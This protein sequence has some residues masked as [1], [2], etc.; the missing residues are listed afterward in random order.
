[1]KIKE[2][3]IK[4]YLFVIIWAL[5]TTILSVFVFPKFSADCIN[6]DS[7]YQYF[8][9]QHS[10][11]EIWELLPQDYSPPVYALLLKFYTMIFGNTLF[12][13]RTM[14]VIIISAIF[15]ITL[16]PFRTAFGTKASIVYT[17]SVFCSATLL[18][19][20]HEIRPTILAFFAVIGI[21]TYAYL[22]YFRTKKA[23]YIGFT[24][25]VIL[26]MYTHNIVML[27]ALG[28]YVLMLLFSLVEK[29]YKKLKSI[30]ISGIIAAV[31]YIPWL[32]VVF[33]QFENAKSSFIE[34][35]LNFD[36]VYKW[37]VSNIILTL[38][39][40]FI[41][42]LLL[43]AFSLVLCFA[44][45]G[46]IDWKKLKGAKTVKEIMHADKA[47]Y[48]T[49]IFV[50]GELILS[51]VIVF[52]FHFIVYPLISE[53]YIYIIGMILLMV[54]SVIVAEM[55]PKIFAI[56]FSVLFIVNG[57]LSVLKVQEKV[58]S[59]T[60]ST[61]V[62]N[63]KKENPDGKIVF[64]HTHEWTIGTLN[65]Y[66]PDAEHYIY[67]KTFTVLNDMSV[68]SK[69]IVDVGEIENIWNYTDKVYVFEPEGTWEDTYSYE[70]IIE[71]LDP[72]TINKHVQYI[73]MYSYLQV[74]CP[75]LLE[76]SNAFTE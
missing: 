50:C 74:C 51:L 17:I 28:I 49:L 63:I 4:N 59:A 67:D 11:A 73:N 35:I 19:Q 41:G 56:V 29:D 32:I 66:F 61:M 52:A 7:S 20:V 60:M 57:T 27:A 71:L 68:I 23:Y 24:V 14:N 25:F 30:F 33:G 15:L 62:E 1:M 39:N 13:M 38:D 40:N 48:K 75:V 37:L 18:N 26:G 10:V 2:W 58:D 76:K 65:Y 3:L 64:L 45:V 42:S 55:S 36:I 70:E 6:Y 47:R 54:I 12:I 8:L 69:N 34:I 5:C 43:V 44:V 53:R 9:T 31:V 21:V 72:D 16:F 46:L 22:V